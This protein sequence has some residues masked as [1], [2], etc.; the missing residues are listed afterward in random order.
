M[1]ATS[2][3]VIVLLGLLMTAPV[4]AAHAQLESSNPAD[5]ARL[6]SR[7]KR[8]TLEFGEA[9]DAGFATVS[10]LGPGGKTHWEAGKAQANGP[11][12]DVPVR[13]L[14]PAGQYVIKYRVLSADGHP[15]SGKVSFRLLNPGHGTPAPAAAGS[16]T[17]GGKPPASGVPLWVWIVGA[18]GLFVAA[19][20]AAAFVTRAPREA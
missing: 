7:P 5:G 10:V 9:V 17:G 2:V 11:K 15:V 4:G 3:L 6:T 13:P 12:V 8:V 14:G 18:A 19:A 20:F 1:R 16:T